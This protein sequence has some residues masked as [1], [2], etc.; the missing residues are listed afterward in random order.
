MKCVNPTLSRGP[1]IDPECT[2][3]SKNLTRVPMWVLRQTAD[4]LQ[5]RLWTARP[6]PAEPTQYVLTGK[7]KDE[8]EDVLFNISDHWRW[9]A[10]DPLKDAPETIGV[11]V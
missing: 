1:A 10:R 2:K 7:T 4:G 5:A 11:W 8:I 3:L 9:M 6:A